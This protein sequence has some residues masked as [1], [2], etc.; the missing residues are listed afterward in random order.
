MI[1]VVRRDLGVQFWGCTE[2]CGPPF[3]TRLMLVLLGGDS[4]CDSPSVPLCPGVIVTV[5]PFTVQRPWLCSRLGA[6]ARDRLCLG[7]SWPITKSWEQL[8]R[9]VSQIEAQ[10]PSRDMVAAAQRPFPVLTCASAALSRTRATGC[11]LKESCPLLCLHPCPSLESDRLE[12]SP[13]SSSFSLCRLGYVTLNPSSHICET[14]RITSSLQ[15][16]ERIQVS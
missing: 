1:L 16:T 8:E 12:S 6:H 3:P 11:G 9:W 14:G 10:G 13:G 7:K 2:T 15:G 4:G 5:P